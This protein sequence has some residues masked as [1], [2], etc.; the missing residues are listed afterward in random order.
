MVL[1]GRTTVCSTVQRLREKER[2][3][4][5]VVATAKWCAR[6]P[7]ESFGEKKAH[8]WRTG[9]GWSLLFGREQAKKIV[10][11]KLRRMKDAN[12]HQGLVDQRATISMSLVGPP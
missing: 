2:G 7:R 6:L 1:V 10:A 9:Q 3:R 8:F 12:F 4:S 11:Q 5:S